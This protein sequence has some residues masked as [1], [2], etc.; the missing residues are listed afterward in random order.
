M[1]RKSVA[2]WAENQ[3]PSFT[4]CVFNSLIKF[5]P[6]I[7][8]SL[9]KLYQLIVTYFMKFLTRIPNIVTIEDGKQFEIFVF[10][11]K[12]EITVSK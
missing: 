4:Y 10:K 3:P 1:S 2:K 7:L 11:I 12:F 8:L 5:K 9:I 6:P